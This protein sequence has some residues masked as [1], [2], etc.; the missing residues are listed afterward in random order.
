LNADVDM[1]SF[2]KRGEC[3]PGPWR[4]SELTHRLLTELTR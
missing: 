3:V 1:A 4:S 2:V